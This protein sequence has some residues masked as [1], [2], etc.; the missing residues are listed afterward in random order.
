MSMPMPMSSAAALGMNLGL[1]GFVD[2]A[3][4]GIIRSMVAI[5]R[6]MCVFFL[7]STFVHYTCDLL[8]RKIILGVDDSFVRV[9]A[10][11]ASWAWPSAA[12]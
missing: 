10:F 8:D 3:G 7:F 2:V 4:G 5:G 11:V 1:G 12:W 6:I 9:I